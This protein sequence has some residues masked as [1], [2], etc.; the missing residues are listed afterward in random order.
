M[1]IYIHIHTVSGF[2]TPVSLLFL[3]SACSGTGACLS[4]NINATICTPSTK[5]ETQQEAI[6]EAKVRQGKNK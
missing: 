5:K 6:D 1:D 3:L 2:Q 4:S